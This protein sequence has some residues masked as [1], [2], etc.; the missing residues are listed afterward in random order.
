M[1]LSFGNPIFPRYLVNNPIRFGLLADTDDPVTME[2]T[3]GSSMVYKGVYGPVVNNPYSNYKV[4]ISIEDIIRPYMTP[5][6]IGPV[7]NII[8]D[9]D[10]NHLSVSIKFTQ[11]S[12]TL[13]YSCDVYNGG[14]SKRLF[15][16]L[17]IHGTDIFSY[18]FFDTSKQFFL[19][20]RTS[21]RHITIKENE[22]CPLFFIVTNKTYSVVTEYGNIFILPEMSLNHLRALSIEG[23]RWYSDRLYN[24]KP[25]FFGIMIDGQYV[26]DVT[27]TEPAPSPDK[28]IIEFRNSFGVYERLEVSGRCVSEPE[29]G[30]DN[31][32]DRYDGTV[33]DYIEQN[34]RLS[35]REVINAEFGYKTPD[36][37]FFARDM[38]QSDERRLIDPAG[39]YH[40]VRVIAENFSHD[41]HPKQ[42][43]SIPLKIRSVDTDISY[44]P[45]RDDSPPDFYFGEPVWLHGVTNGYGFLFA[46]K[47]LNTV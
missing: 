24:K 32:F 35:I 37:F 42:P 36:E 4:D 31:A 5:V 11:G 27:I 3:V 9:A 1:A 18:K 34:E 26:F 19:T 47:P 6:N 16:D 40:N 13:N 28:Y 20:T 30:E 7:Y 43:G 38:L 15:R 44:S 21:G 46:D 45:E 14:I 29:F 33:N 39:N 23:V 10:F 17:Y 2:V 41:L 25:S 22:I 8:Y 12:N